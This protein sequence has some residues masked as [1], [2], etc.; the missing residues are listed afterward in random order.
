MSRRTE[1]APTVRGSIAVAAL[2]LTSALAACDVPNFEGPQLQDPPQGFLLQPDS[3][4]E[5]AMFGHLPEVHHD[6]WVQSLPPYS[7]IRINGYSGTLTLDDVL[8]AQ[9]SA[10]VHAPDPDILFGAIEPHTIDGREAWGWEERI[11]TPSRG[12]PW[13]AYRVMVPYDTISYTIE[14]STEDPQFKAGAPATLTAVISAFGVGE[15]EYNVSLIALAIGLLL[16]TVYLSRAR[17]RTRA[18]RLK[19]MN[20][21]KI[22]KKETDPADAAQEVA[23]AAPTAATG[24]PDSAVTSSSQ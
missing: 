10:R 16:L 8:A 13:V 1:R 14:F 18:E 5:R 15:T 20:L 4:A 22:E 23:V 19:S 2:V 11:D 21:V 9:D 7:T 24:A 17:A 12:I 3:R 6:A